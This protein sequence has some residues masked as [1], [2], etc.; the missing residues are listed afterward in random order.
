[1]KFD[2]ILMIN[3]PQERDLLIQG[4]H[5]F[6]LLSKVGLQDNLG[7]KGLPILNSVDFED[8]SCATSSYFSDGFID[9]VESNFVDVFGELPQPNFN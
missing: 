9:M 7:C 1:M 2:D 4:F 3:D 6:F 8:S 5:S